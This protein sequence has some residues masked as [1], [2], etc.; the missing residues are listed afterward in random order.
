MAVPIV[1]DRSLYAARRVR[2]AR[3]AGDDFLVREAAETL[4]ERLSGL[5]RRFGQ[6]LD[7]GTRDT[8]YS[9]LEP[10]AGEWL[11]TGMATEI[12]GIS[13]VAD[14]E[15]LPFADFHFDLV[16]SVLNLHAVNDLPGSLVQIRHALAPGGL[17]VAALFGGATLNELRRAFAAGEAAILGGASPRVAPIADVRDMG[18]LL[19]RTGFVMSVADLE[20]FTVRYRSFA[21]L[22]RDLRVLGET[23][24]L[25]GR[26]RRPLR[27]DVLAS[28]L[29]HYTANDS[30]SEGRLIATFD[31]LYLT[32]WKAV[33]KT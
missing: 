17:F 29:A 8:S 32:G 24:A 21:T 14:E 15:T 13:A 1:F 6:A 30:D 27:R 33:A 23:N 3:I 20:R 12:K 7:L 4:A 28:A 10:F 22:G 25:A 2:A 9:L 31:I 5:N 16:A 11:R 19:Q 26:R 18:A